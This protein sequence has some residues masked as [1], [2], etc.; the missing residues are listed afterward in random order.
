MGG[1]AFDV[2]TALAAADAAAWGAA[3]AWMTA[4]PCMP[5]PKVAETSR[6]PRCAA[7]AE[8]KEKET[9]LSAAAA[10]TGLRESL[11]DL[12]LGKTSIEDVLQD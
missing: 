11:V 8:D 7:Q 12:V 5:M 3:D 9:P 10:F 4:L 1:S 6:A 2:A